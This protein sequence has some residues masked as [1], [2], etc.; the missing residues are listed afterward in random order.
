MMNGYRACNMNVRLVWTSSTNSSHRAKQQS[1]EG[2]KSVTQSS[3]RMNNRIR[4]GIDYLHDEFD[5]SQALEDRMRAVFKIQNFRLCQRGVCN[6][7]MDERDIVVIMPTGGGKS[8][9]YQLPALFNRGVTLVISP[10][11]SLITD[12]IMHLREAG[13]EA[14]KITGSTSKADANDITRRLRAMADRTLAPEDKAIQLCY[15]TPEKIGKSNTFKGLIN[16]LASS[17][18][19]GRIVI[20]EAHC[21][22]QLGHDFRPDYQNL[23]ILRQLCPGV[24]ITALSATCP[25]EVLDDLIKTLHLRRYRV[26]SKPSTLKDTIQ[27]IVDYIASDHP[28]D[29]GIKRV[30]ERLGQDV[31]HADKSDRDKEALHEAW[32]KGQVK[33]VCATIAFGLGIDKGDVRF[34]IHEKMA[35]TRSPVEQVEMGI[36]PDC[37]LLYRAQDYSSLGAIVSSE[38]QGQMKRKNIPSLLYKLRALIGWVVKAMVDFGQNIETLSYFSFAAKIELS[39]WAT[40]GVDIKVE[41]WQI[42]KVAEELDSVGGNATVAMLANL[43]RGKGGASV[44][45]STKGSGRGRGADK[46]SKQDFDVQQICGGPVGLSGDDTER[47]V[48]QL[49]LKG[50]LKERIHVNAYNTIVYL[51]PGPQALRFTRLK[52][53]ADVESKASL[54]FKCCMPKKEKRTRKKKADDETVSGS[55]RKARGKGRASQIDS[56]TFQNDWDEDAPE[57]SQ[58]LVGPSKQKTKPVVIELSSD[59]EGDRDLDGGYWA[60]NQRGRTFSST[61][62]SGIA[63]TK[64]SLKRSR[65]STSS[66]L[67]NTVVLNYSDIEVDT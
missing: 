58:P 1:N 49:L 35:T 59:D 7:A 45:V 67:R 32:H 22:S 40:D 38:K 18:R 27:W 57:M 24:P 46:K 41:A 44:S 19:L 53:K 28:R 30:A 11:I 48:L 61:Q 31:Y 3:S 2:G 60:V 37:I 25:P 47:L 16:K 33:V 51:V 9:T 20:D 10:L 14:V 12:Q 39:S 50:F 15:V 66:A 43:S 52:S 4:D 21:V 56:A 42:L 5:W 29:T 8:L 34:V 62:T 17:R 36:L 54:E 63:V 23:H 65:S 6:A 13:V 64:S 55:T 26:V